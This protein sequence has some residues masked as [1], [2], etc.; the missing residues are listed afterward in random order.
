MNSGLERYL[1][2]LGTLACSHVLAAYASFLWE[3]DDDDCGGDGGGAAPERAAGTTGQ[4]ME[5]ASAAV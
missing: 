5:L 2:L 1:T 3:Q 4:V